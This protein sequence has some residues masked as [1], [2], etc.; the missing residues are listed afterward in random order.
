MSRRLTILVVLAVAVQVSAYV[1]LTPGMARKWETGFIMLQLRMPSTPTLQDG[2]TYISSAQAALGAWNTVLEDVQFH[3]LTLPQDGPYPLNG[4][5]EVVFTGDVAGE[6]FPAGVLAVTVQYIGQRP[7]GVEQIVEADVYLNAS[8]AWDAY[9]GP[10]QAKPDFRR[11][12]LHE[13]GHVLGLGHPDES[14][15]TV[16]ALMNREVPNLETLQ[17]DDIAGAQ[18][19]YRVPGSVPRPA[20]DLQANA[21]PITLVS[22]TTSVTGTNVNATVE[23]DEYAPGMER[24]YRTV[25]WKW[26]PPTA[27][28]LTVTTAGSNFDTTLGIWV[29]SR[30]GLQYRAGDDDVNYPHDLTSATTLTVQRGVEYLIGVD[31]YLGASG[32]I[33]LNF[34]FVQ[35]EAPV[36]SLQ[37]PATSYLPFGGSVTLSVDGYGVP[38]PTFRWQRSVVIDS[39][40]VWFDLSDGGQFS[41]VHTRQLTITDATPELRDSYFRCVLTNVHGTDISRNAGLVIAP[42]QAPVVSLALSPERHIS[43]SVAITVSAVDPEGRLAHANLWVQTPQRG[44]LTIRADDSIVVAKEFSAAHNAITGP[45]T[46]TRSFTFT[47]VDGPGEYR[48][49]FAAVDTVGVRSDAPAQVITVIAEPIVTAPENPR[50]VLLPGESTT[51][52]IAAAPSGGSLSY[53]WTR[54]GI[55]LPGATGPSLTVTGPAEGEADYYVAIVTDANGSTRAAPFFVRVAPLETQPVAW[56]TGSAVPLELVDAIALSASDTTSLALRRNGTL[57]NFNRAES[58]PGS[59]VG[60]VALSPGATHTLALAADGRVHSHGWGDPPLPADLAD[61]VGI[62]AGLQTS[63]VLRSD[64]TVAGWRMV[65]HLGSSE[66]IAT[67]AGVGNIVALA[68]G[69]SHVLALRADGRVLAWGGNSSAALAVPED[70][71]GVVALAAGRNTS[72]ALTADGR[73]TAWGDESGGLL[74]EVRA[75]TGVRQL[76]AGWDFV[77]VLKQDGTVVAFGA[78]EHGNT[79]VP[80]GLSGVMAVSARQRQAVALR[81][82]AGDMAP[83]IVTQPQ[84]QTVLEGEAAEFS[85]VV[86]GAAP[87]RY[88]WRRNGIWIIGATSSTYRREDVKAADEGAQFDVMVDN[89]R[90]SVV[91]VKVPLTVKL[92]PVVSLQTAPRRAVEP[93]AS[94]AMSVTVSGHGPVSYQWYRRGVALPG[95]TAPDLN[96]SNLTPQDAGAY[97]V[98]ATDSH[99]PGYGPPTFVTVM[100]VTT[101]AMVWGAGQTDGGQVPSDLGPVVAVNAAHNQRIAIRRD[102]SLASWMTA[103]Y[104]RWVPTHAAGY[105]ALAS[106]NQ[107]FAALAADGSMV[108]WSDGATTVP[109]NDARRFVAIAAGFGRNFALRV[110]GSLAVWEDNTRFAAPPPGFTELVA[111]DANSDQLIGLKADGTVVTWDYLSQAAVPPPAGLSDVQEVA[112]GGLTFFAVKADGTVVAWGSGNGTIVPPAVTAV[113]ELAANHFGVLAR[114][115][116]GQVVG[117]GDNTH[118]QFTLPG[119][120]RALHVSLGYNYAMAVHDTALDTIPSI[121]A[122]PVARTVREGLSV[123]FSV[124]AAGVG[125]FAYQWRRNGVPI[126]GA[127][128]ATLTI[129]H[130]EPTHAGQIDVLVTNHIGSVTSAGATLTVI[131][132]PQIALRVPARQLLAPGEGT[133]LK[134]DIVSTGATS[135]QWYRNGRPIPGASRSSLPIATAELLDSGFYFLD[136]TDEIGTRRSAPMFVRVSPSQTQ[137]ISWGPTWSAANPPGNWTDVVELARGSAFVALRANGEVAA[138]GGSNAYGEATVPAGLSDVVAIAAGPYG[139]GALRSDGRLTIFGS[140]FLQP[141]EN[142]PPVVAFAMGT[143]SV[144]ALLLDGTV[145]TWGINQ[146]NVIPAPS[147]LDNVVA[148]AAGSFHCLALRAN[149]TVT[150]WGEND[151]GQRNV[152]EGLQDVI[153]ISAGARFSLA[154]KA[155]GTVVGW[156]GNS[157]GELTMPALAN[158]VRIGSYLQSSLALRGDGTVIGWGSSYEGVNS[159]PANAHPA[160]AIG[161]GSSRGFAILEQRPAGNRPPFAALALSAERSVDQTVALDVVVGDADANYS[162]AHLW[163]QSPTLGWRT[164]RAD[165][166]LAST[167]SLAATDTV[168]AVTGAHLRRFTFDDGPGEYRFVLQAVDSAGISSPAMELQVTVEAPPPLSGFESWRA[169]RWSEHDLNDATQSGALADPDG[170]G[171]VNLLEYAL[172]SDPLV[173]ASVVEME[174]SMQGGEWLLVFSRPSARDDLEYAV[175]SSTDLVEWSSAGVVLERIGTGEIEVWRAR[176]AASTQPQFLRLRVTRQ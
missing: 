109:S 71:A 9:R 152:P 108:M 83:L 98:V 123:E 78:N 51:L 143:Y 115:S 39:M 114:K 170:D 27:G 43:Q 16:T 126:D 120:L 94:V 104:P 136:V 33:R 54:N 149:G 141:P 68:A 174:V 20:N 155:D 92:R 22:G 165:D 148:V 41:G 128:L 23:F 101:R 15:Q 17:P 90:G 58:P 18:V 97:W 60:F 140:S 111:I 171:H 161:I 89:H 2:S 153:A 47:L 172:G 157:S 75:L 100:P 80:E 52:T 8:V 125:P 55:A 56:G 70:L 146:G 53:Q 46:E 84:P 81:R 106:Y 102:G 31:G 145:R 3:G 77:V 116:D 117:W 66:P 113:S 160:V 151:W 150:A 19:L 69:E 30:H 67:P 82:A 79:A 159:V 59:P 40:Q 122:S 38:A 103:Q 37:P 166:S 139:S 132:L 85:V 137:W 95:Q 86:T 4:S 158:I 34:S 175:E 169:D 119:G 162:H 44:W 144:V 28:E 147:G 93:G 61:I 88:Q 135:L 64:G 6:A 130:V 129:P 29:P 87:L 76:A 133:L 25:W 154:L 121:Q 105:V 35:R 72:F 7:D 163:V 124:V 24:A 156:G 49:E 32:Q 13:L 164:L 26:T 65:P 42:N 63:F 138:W 36:V 131:P 118:A 21:F 11:V 10:L 57:V 142:L 5:N 173:N 50:R 134:V 74:S 110:D 91:S 62:A 1:F 96:L 73:V 112:A 107:Q 168:A 12:L 127:T 99:G 48:F 176:C 167:H 45:G 14:G